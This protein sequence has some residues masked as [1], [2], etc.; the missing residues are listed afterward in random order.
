MKRRS[1]PLASALLATLL[2]ALPGE[3]SA[4]FFGFGFSFGGGGWWHPWHHNYWGR[5]W[6]RSWGYPYGYGYGWGNPWLSGPYGPYYYPPVLVA[7]A[8]AAPK[9][10]EK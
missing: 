9:S 10:S 8:P 5:P 3:S 4:F 7:P 1:F 2:L 6:Y